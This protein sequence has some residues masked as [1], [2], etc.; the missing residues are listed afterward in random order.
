MSYRITFLQSVVDEHKQLDE[1]LLSFSD[2]IKQ[3]HG[4]LYATAEINA[5]DQQ[6]A[7]IHNKVKYSIFK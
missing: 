6:P 7:I 3:F 5:A 4:K 1:L 2:W